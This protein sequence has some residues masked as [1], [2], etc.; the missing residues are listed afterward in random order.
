ML[1]E[2]LRAMSI[3]AFNFWLNKISSSNLQ[4]LSSI[5]AFFQEQN[6][7]I[8]FQY[9]NKIQQAQDIDINYITCTN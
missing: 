7:K 3:K 6:I 8:H 2:I 1:I 5:I 9:L 4:I